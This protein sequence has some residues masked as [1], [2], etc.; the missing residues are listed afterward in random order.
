[1][2]CIFCIWLVIVEVI[3]EMIELIARNLDLRIG[4]EKVN[5]LALR[6]D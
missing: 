4:N 5:Q 6:N 3:V 1:M 2:D